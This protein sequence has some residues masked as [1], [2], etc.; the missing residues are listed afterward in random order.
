V[1]SPQA[2]VKTA[3]QARTAWGL[4]V[5]PI[6]QNPGDIVQWES[7]PITTKPGG[8]AWTIAAVNAIDEWGITATYALAILQYTNLRLDEVWLEAYGVLGSAVEPLRLRL[9]AGNGRLML[10]TSDD[11]NL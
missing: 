6:P 1:T 11:L 10:R 9:R 5:Y 2:I 7:V 3:G 8:G 4:A